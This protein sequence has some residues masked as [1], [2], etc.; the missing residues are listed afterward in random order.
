MLKDL[1]ES[2]AADHDGRER[3]READHFV[4]KKDG[5]WEPQIISML[6]QRPR[7]TF[8]KCNAVI[9]DIMGEMNSMDF[10]S[11]VSPAGGAASKDTSKHYD[12]I[13]RNIENISSARY[14]YQAAAKAMVTTGIGGWRIV[15]GFRD[16][17]SFQQDLM[18]KYVSNFIDRVWFDPGAEMPDMS[19]AG[20]GFMLTSM[21]KKDYDRDFPKGSGSSVGRDMT[22]NVYSYKKPDEVVIGEYLY[23]K[24]AT[25]ELALMSNNAII[26]V[27]DD[28]AQIRDEL[29]ASGVTVENTRKR[30]VKTV[31]QRLFDGSDWL[32]SEKKTVFEFVP[33]VPVFGNFEISEDK[34]IY[35]GVVEKIM[36]PQR[37]LNYAES[38]KIEEGALAPR[39]KLMMTRRQASKDLS[40]LRT[41]NTN[42][43]PVQ[44]YTHVD[45][46]QPP[47]KIGGPQ[48]NPGLTET[49]QSM[50]NH[51]NSTSSLP[52]VSQGQRAGLQSGVALEMLQNKGDNSNFKYFTAM[53]IAITHSCRMLIKAIPK[54]YDTRQEMR[55]LQQ[56]GTVDTITIKER[57][58]DE[59]TGRIVE[60]NDLS[61]GQYDV[62]CSSGPAF[63]NQQQKTT[64]AMMELA[65][66]D[67]S[68]LQM[69]ADIYLNNIDA[70]G[71]DQLADRKR[72]QMIQQ[73]LIPQGQ[74]TDEEKAVV[75]QAQQQGAQ[76]TAVDQ[77]LIAQAQS[78]A[79]RAQANTQDIIS[80]MNDRMSSHDLEVAKL[81][82]KQQEFEAKSRQAQ[83]KIAQDQQK[84]VLD[85]LK[86]QDEQI[87]TQAETL[88]IIKDAMGV[89]AMVGPQNTR[90]YIQQAEALT[91]TQQ[92]SV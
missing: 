90:A 21:A 67:P 58:M 32:G 53:E 54:V 74:M 30:D 23:Q 37:V 71:M 4:N 31:Y 25:K 89:D 52:D 11:K 61:K 72:A 81:S 92:G 42:A 83:E 27:N 15:T 26:E 75:Q 66:I 1:Q 51:I 88:K 34:V 7:Y 50:Q 77:A 40:T 63:N 82:L 24:S 49:T 70:P 73:G 91:Q 44:T 46:Q 16:S 76:P 62:T 14:I 64:A 43:D 8:D 78:E 84:H 5:Q 33:L 2:Q 48:I 38:R 47:Y 6:N 60:I 3:A 19:D 87:K 10:A 17:D 55:L 85:V 68:I 65:A 22:N 86:S 41:M 45:G 20:F 12:G 59:E 69:G 79:E 9:D 39:D 57:I 29:A 35:W 80:K 18:L 28:F 56:D 13:V 36:D